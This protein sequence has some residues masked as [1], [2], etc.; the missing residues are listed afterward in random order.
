LIREGFFKQPNKRTIEEVVKALE[1]SGLPTG[2]KED[3]IVGFLARRA[4]KGVLKMSKGSN[5][6][7]YWTD[8]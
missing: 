8:S 2:G 3:K 4:K 6:W 5:G 1:T 7:V